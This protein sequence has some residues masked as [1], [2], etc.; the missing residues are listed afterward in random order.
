MSRRR[1]THDPGPHF[2]S[3]NLGWRTLS[4]MKYLLDLFHQFPFPLDLDGPW[5][6]SS[7]SGSKSKTVGRKA[8]M[9]AIRRKC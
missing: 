9:N 4:G 8:T 6:V 1:V 7:P 3:A 2:F 5:A